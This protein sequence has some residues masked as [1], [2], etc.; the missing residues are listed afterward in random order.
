ML[1]LVTVL[2]GSHAKRLGLVVVGG[3][4]VWPCVHERVHE[5]ARGHAHAR[6]RA[7][8]P[9]PEFAQGL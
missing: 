8:L 5:R 6:S 4:G 7:W 1:V 3:D 2:V 9:L